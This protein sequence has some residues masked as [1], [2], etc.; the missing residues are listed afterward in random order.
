MNYHNSA[1]TNLKGLMRT[2][3]CGQLNAE[4]VGQTVTL[5]GWVNKTRDLGGVVFVDVRDKYGVTQ[6]AFDEFQNDIAILKTFSLESVIMATGIVR[7]RP[8]SALNKKW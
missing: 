8:D 6:L 1:S 3:S 7:K 2:H 5:C 4:H